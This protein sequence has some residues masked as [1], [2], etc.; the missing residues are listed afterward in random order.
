MKILSGFTLPSKENVD[1]DRLLMDYFKV[2]QR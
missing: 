2:E 1:H